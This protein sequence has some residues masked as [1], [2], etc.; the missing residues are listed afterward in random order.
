MSKEK[1]GSLIENLDSLIENWLSNT[2]SDI[3]FQRQTVYRQ[4]KTL[5]LW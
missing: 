1:L 3:E 5:L 2:V 4:Q